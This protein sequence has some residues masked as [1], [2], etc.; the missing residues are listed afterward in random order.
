VC[1]I[2]ERECSSQGVFEVDL[3]Q[4]CRRLYGGQWEDVNIAEFLTSVN[5]KVSHLA[6]GYTR[7]V[8]QTR[9]QRRFCLRNHVLRE[10][11]IESAVKVTSSLVLLPCAPSFCHIQHNPGPDPLNHAYPHVVT[12]TTTSGNHLRPFYL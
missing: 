1:N 10:T 8:I 6:L 4:T 12:A 5:V 9:L 2:G 7:R 11:V 3:Y